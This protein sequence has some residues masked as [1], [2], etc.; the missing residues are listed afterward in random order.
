MQ[1]EVEKVISQIP[2]VAFA[3]SKTGT[4]EMASDP[5]PPNVPIRSL[6]PAAEAWRSEA[7]L[8]K[9]IAEKAEAMEQH[10]GHVDEERG[11]EGHGHENEEIKA[12]GQ[13][14]KLLKLIELTLKAL[15][16][17]N[18]EFTQ[19][20]QMRFNELIAGVR[21]DVAV[22]VF[23][24]EFENMEP[25]AQ[26]IAG[27]LRD[28]KGAADVKVEQTKG[29]PVMNIEI[30]RSAISRYGLNVADVQDVVAIAIGGR[31][32]GLVFQGD[33]RLTWSC[34]AGQH[35]AR[36]RGHPQPADPAAARRKVRDHHKCRR[37]W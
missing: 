20:I 1:F 31:E 33:R 5:M 8:E 3:F 18:Y 36:H 11:E 9:L 4:A 37:R 24:D 13:K 23:G 14:G 7:E 22:K 34:A 6:F 21:S 10:G 30:D 29:L 32:A 2:E 19:P 26:A 25:T 35:A 12:E 27:I 17:N 28:V 15:P 16:G